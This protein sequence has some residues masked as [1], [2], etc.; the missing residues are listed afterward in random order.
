MSKK[1]E[2]PI[3]MQHE[4]E[5]AKSDVL[6]QIKEIKDDQHKILDAM[7]EIVTFIKDLPRADYTVEKDGVKEV[8]SGPLW[9]LI[10]KA[11]KVGAF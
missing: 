10:K 11:K 1:N 4:E 8:K 9:A 2:K 7:K 3:D 5:M 6:Q